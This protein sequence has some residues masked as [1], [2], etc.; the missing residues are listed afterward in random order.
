MFTRCSTAFA[1][2]AVVIYCGTSAGAPRAPLADTAEKNDTAA[3]RALLSQEVN[4]NSPQA[5]GMTAVHWAVYHDDA[6]VVK[7]LIA[8]G[9]DVK[10]ANRC[11]VAPLSTACENGSAAIVEML[12]EAGADPKASLPGGETVLMTAARTGQV[13]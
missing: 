11:G 3:I 6:K 9:A 12:L 1:F 8:A 13:G 7:L 10:I 4:V 5:D 2:A